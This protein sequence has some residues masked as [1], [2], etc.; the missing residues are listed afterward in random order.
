MYFSI[1]LNC[2]LK[3]CYYDPSDHQ[4]RTTPSTIVY[5]YLFCSVVGI[6]IVILKSCRVG[7]S[8]GGMFFITSIDGKYTRN[9]S[10]FLLRPRVLGIISFTFAYTEHCSIARG[11]AGT[12]RPNPANQQSKE[13]EIVW[14][15]NVFNFQFE[16]NV[17]R[18]SLKKENKKQ[19][20]ILKK[21]NKGQWSVDSRAQTSQPAISR[22]K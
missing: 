7:V 2:I 16:I 9:L 13:N 10:A 14:L 3:K 4:P 12:P 21:S 18:N 1:I 17:L 19:K 11:D 8:A 15:K 20:K 22:H 5:W 6:V